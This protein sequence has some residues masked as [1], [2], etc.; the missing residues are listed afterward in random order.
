VTR[1]VVVFT[2]TRADLFPLSPVLAA[3]RCAP[4]LDT[5]LI[6]SGTTGN[7]SFGD[8]LGDLDLTAVTVERIADDLND[9]D[10]PAMT[11]GGLR[12]AAGVSA[13]LDRVQPDAFVVLGDRWELLFAVPP[14][15]LWGIPIV[16]LH[17]GEVTEGAIDDRIRHAVTKLADLHCV[18][19]EDAA[20]R[21]RQLGEPADRIVVTGAPS[22]D[23]MTSVVAADDAA[24]ATLL[25]RP[26]RRPFVLVTYHAPTAGDIDATQGAREVLTAVANTCASAVVTHPGLDHGR[27]GVLEGIRAVAAEAPHLIEV[28]T[29]GAAYLPVLAAADVVVGNSSSGI[30]EAASF[31]VPVVN[32][33]D[34]QR[35]RIRGSNVLDVIEDRAAIEAGIRTCLSEEF[36]ARAR[37]AVNPYG[38]GKAARR[39]VDVIH[40]ATAGGLSRK[41]FVD[42]GQPS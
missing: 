4:D 25:G 23:R 31:G 16:H 17:G 1:R 37:A 8:P 13:L 42:L 24:L 21:V 36:R 5:T 40:R 10:P 32:V 2:A 27:D 15:A 35:G 34:R 7:R 30:I 9:A 19:T 26:V 18:S 20:E 12:I 6:A 28:A 39:I 14:A 29:L 41:A 3:L 22:L 11:A 38:D 33:G